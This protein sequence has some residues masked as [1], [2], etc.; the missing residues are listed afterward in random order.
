MA[1]TLVVSVRL[2]TVSQSSVDL[3]TAQPLFKTALHAPSHLDTSA[4][5]ILYLSRY[6]VPLIMNDSC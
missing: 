6:F 3:P 2:F 1:P 4:S 5:E